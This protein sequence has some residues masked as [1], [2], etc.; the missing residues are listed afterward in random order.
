[1]ATFL[2]QTY[3]D[4]V[5]SFCNSKMKSRVSFICPFNIMG[6]ESPLNIP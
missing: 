6:F 5:L 2:T 1:M 4:R 3:V